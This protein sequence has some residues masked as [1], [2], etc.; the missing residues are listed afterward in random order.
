MALF[1]VT[2]DGNVLSDEPEGLMDVVS[3]LKRDK[4][5]KGQVLLVDLTLKFKGGTDGYNIL[6]PLIDCQG[7]CA[8]SEITIEESC[9]N[10]TTFATIFEGLIFY[11]EV[12][13]HLFPCIL[14]CQ[15]TDNSYFAKID[16]NKNIEAFVNVGR[17]KNDEPIITEILTVAF[18]DVATGNYT[19]PVNVWAVWYCFRFIIDYMTDGE[20]DFAS[21][22]FYG[23]LLSGDGR[24]M[25]ITTGE[26]IRLGSGG[27]P[28]KAPFIS[29]QK[30]FEE[31]NKKIR[32]AFSIE[33]DSVTG[34]K[35]MR[36]EP[37]N[38]FF[39]TG[40]STTLNNVKGIVKSVNT[41]EL[42]SRLKIGSSE[43]IEYV[44]GATD[45]PTDINFAGFK[46][47]SY[48]MTGKCN[49]DNTLDLVSDWIIDSN[50]IQDVFSNGNTGYDDD[51]FFVMADY[52]TDPFNQVAIQTDVFD[53]GGAPLFYND[54]LRNAN[55]AQRWLGGIPNTIA[56]YL[57]PAGN[58]EFQA[59]KL[60]T[61]SDDIITTSP[62]F[63]PIAF[64]DDF[65]A[66][67]SDAGSNYS[68][69]TS[70]YSVPATGYFT[71]FTLLQGVYTFNDT[72]NNFGGTIEIRG[73]A[74]VYDA[75][76]FA[77]G[78]LLATHELFEYISFAAHGDP[79]PYNLSGSAFIHVN[80]TDKVLIAIEVLPLLTS[81]SY[82]GITIAPGSLFA[83]T[84]S[85]T[86][87]GNFQTY[88]PEDFK[89]YQYEIKDYPLTF[90]QYQAII[91]NP[92]KLL[93]FNDGP[94]DYDGWIENM[95]YHHVKGTADF[96]LSK[97][98]FKTTCE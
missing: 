98:L 88:S 18:F 57:G 19:N 85:V 55:V 11:T 62:A 52:I 81:S 8:F 64:E 96:V 3:E 95:K 86:S 93:A 24:F 54:F 87:G 2:L 5:I 59:S 14:E 38:Y 66:P 48:T 90:A 37:E 21:D 67:N 82:V 84:N 73:L 4:A 30:L 27:N 65:T 23:N 10:D 89:A 78:N 60:T 33:T 63:E 77:G 71:F 53:T 28:T 41:A 7:F 97:S 72:D 29:F 31:V 68:V 20:M 50:V 1:R 39:N 49:I 22:Y 40:T 45:F 47:E 35:T 16:N 69:I 94:N 51:I 74:R 75:A 92:L 43:T 46:E 15:L 56:L 34:R 79:V 17:S 76:G 61:Q 42:Y 83:C 6:K 36:I 13:E 91:A 80:A 44:A 25:T 26:Q 12:K 9:N 58:N 70:E 32:I